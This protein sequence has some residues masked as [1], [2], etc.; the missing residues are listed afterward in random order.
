LIFHLPAAV[1]CGPTF[2]LYQI[3]SSYI[4][5]GEIY[6]LHC[7]ETGIPRE[8]PILFVGEKIRKVLR[9]YRQQTGKK[10]VRSRLQPSFLRPFSFIIQPT[11]VEY[12]TLKKDTCDEISIK[13]VPDNVLSKVDM[14]SFPLSRPNQFS[15]YDPYHG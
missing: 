6:D 13:M 3:N 1:A 8:E 2:R 7:E 15:V 12:V 4:S 10:Q 11:K 9:E 14:I 5:L